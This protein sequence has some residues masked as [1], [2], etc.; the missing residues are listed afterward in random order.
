MENNIILKNVSKEYRDFK[1]NDI[2]F[3]VPKG[4]VVGLIG[5]NGVGKT[6]TI[7]AILNI[8]SS[9]GTIIVLGKDNKKYEQE[10]KQEI[11]VVL[12]DS[13]LSD[14]IDVKK[15]DSIMKDFYKNWDSKKYFNYI[16][17]FKL[18]KD[19]MIND[20]STG[21]KMKLKII[22][23]ISHD[24]KIL[25]LDEPTSGLDPVVR[26]EILDI[27][28]EFIAEDEERSIL[29][30][31]HITSDLEHISDYIVFIDNGH[32]IFDLPT[33]ELLEN[34]G[35]VKCKKEEFEKIKKEDY[36]KYKKEK[37]QYEILVNDRF[38]FKKTYP[39]NT[40]DR[41]SIEDIMLFYIKGENR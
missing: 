12:D 9:Q 31:T 16:E 1:L 33:E 17:K 25:I 39:I 4:S 15:I 29:M 24:P 38:K 35:I 27:F 7:K 41:A 10:I 21:M 20:F 8:I 2:S 34:Y 11:G 5:E 37:Y 14:Y 30:S 23:A 40:I 28:R 22:T 13:F 32:I 3:N 36:I 18:P 19:K 26:N 6:T